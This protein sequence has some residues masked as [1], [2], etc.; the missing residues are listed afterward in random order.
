MNP[1][2]LAGVSQEALAL[3][4]TAIQSGNALKKD[5]TTQ[6]FTTT[7]GLTGYELEAPSKKL[8][9]VLAPTRNMIARKKASRGS[10]A[11]HWKAITKINATGVQASTAFG[12]AGALVSTT[13]QDFMAAYK[14]VSLGDSV[15]YDAQIQAQEFEDLRATAGVNL[16]YAVM[17]EEDKL[18][19]GGQNFSIG[20]P[21]AP[22]LTASTTGGTIGAVTVYVAVCARTMQGWYSGAQTAASASA[23]TGALTG[24]TNSVNA[25]VSTIRG[26]VVYDWYV[27][28]AAGTLYYY[29]ST[30]TTQ[31]KITSVPTQ[32]A[33]TAALPLLA[34][35]AAAEASGATVDNSGDANAFNGLIASL[36]GDYSGGTYVTHGTGASTGAYFGDLGGATLTGT[37][38]GIAEIDAALLALWNSAKVS[39]TRMIVNAQQQIDITNKLLASGLAYTLFRPDQL[40][41]RQGAIG[42]ALVDTYLNKAVNGRPIP[43][44]S[45][46]WL[47]PGT[48][49]LVTE[50]LPYPNSRVANVLEVRTQQEYQQVEYA[51]A[52]LAGQVGGGPR[53]DFE[54]RAQE[55]LINYFP[56][57]MGIIQNIANG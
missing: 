51:T 21:G 37:P 24:T 31:V 22:T 18:L 45:D 53:Y 42:G 11:A 1:T 29:S 7:T 13:E 57:G 33:A 26:A 10:E 54:V 47:P 46:P 41:E 2:D 35:P 39:P 4:R 17:M 8:F 34:A 19:K 20:T 28:S 9:P 25:S 12:Y 44:E 3:F 6:G 27:G 5:A 52:R 40:A 14:I 38:D 15:E 55:T 48:I 16:L 50:S 36:T 32:A 30:V 43:I 49:L 23:N 56:G